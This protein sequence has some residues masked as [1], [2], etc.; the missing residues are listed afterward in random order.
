MKRITSRF[1]LLIATAAVLPLIVYGFV[2]MGRLKEGTETSVREGNLEVA[3]QV[4]SQL[5]LY[6]DNN[7][8][9][10][11]SVG[12]ELSATSLEQWQQTRI[13]TNHVLEFPE[14]R[15]LTLLDASGR[16]IVTSRIG[17]FRVVELDFD[18]VGEIGQGFADELFRVFA[19][20]HPDIELKPVNAGPGVAP[21]IR[22]V[23][24]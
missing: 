11:R 14:F 3:E 19:N 13:L 17:G 16:T 15:E 2:S 1:V 4:A 21:M 20:A 18:G 23:R 9:I 6:I 12:Q 8:R 10:L 7:A 22:R 5:K 24:P